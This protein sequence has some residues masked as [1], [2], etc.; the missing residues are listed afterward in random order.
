MLLWQPYLWAAFP[1]SPAQTSWCPSL[2][3]HTKPFSAK[4]RPWYRAPVLWPSPSPGAQTHGKHFCSS[5]FVRFTCPA[6]SFYDRIACFWT[7]RKAVFLKL[8]VCSSNKQ[9]NKNY[10]PQKEKYVYIRFNHEYMRGWTKV[11]QNNTSPIVT[12]DSGSLSSLF[13]LLWSSEFDLGALKVNLASHDF[14]VRQWD[15]AVV[16]K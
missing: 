13:P 5:P 4:V 12:G 6:M 10:N 9:T 11:L 3:T 1:A 8:C 14:T 15:T 16:E 7:S 2:S